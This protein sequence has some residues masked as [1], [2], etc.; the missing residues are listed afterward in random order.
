MLAGRGFSHDDFFCQPN[1]VR[2]HPSSTADGVPGDSSAVSCAGTV[3]SPTGAIT[4]TIATTCATVGRMNEDRNEN[5]RV[6][7]SGN[8]R[9]I[10]VGAGGRKPARKSLFRKDLRLVDPPRFHATGCYPSTDPTKE[11]CVI[12]TRRDRAA[13]RCPAGSFLA[14]HF[15][16]PA[17]FVRPRFSKQRIRMWSGRVIDTR[18]NTGNDECRRVILET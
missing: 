18:F 10:P 16:L 13:W 14:R 5:R 12:A 15:P 2:R 17:R 8:A 9:C 6:M 4:D 1:F 7:P 3:V 11:R